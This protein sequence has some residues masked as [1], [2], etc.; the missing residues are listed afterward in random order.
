MLLP[1]M[2]LDFVGTRVS[3]ALALEASSDGA[4]MESLVNAM[5]GSFMASALVGAFESRGAA[6]LSA[7]VYSGPS[8]N[9]RSLRVE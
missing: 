4:E 6:Q 9:S 3:I 7:R 8:G 2:L 5:Y 1:E